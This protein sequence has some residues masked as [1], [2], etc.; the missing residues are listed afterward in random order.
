MANMISCV[1]NVEMST[2]FVQVTIKTLTYFHSLQN[3][4]QMEYA[5]LS[6]VPEVLYT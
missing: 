5:L 4:F 6:R 1:L 3:V 2:G